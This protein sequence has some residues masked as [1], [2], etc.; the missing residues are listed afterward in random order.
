[1]ER[2]LQIADEVELF[3][4]RVM[5]LEEKVSLSPQILA[6]LTEPFSTIKKPGEFES[7]YPKLFWTNTILVVRCSFQP[8][9]IK[10]LGIPK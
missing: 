1:M 5:T 7:K 3:Q 10:Y 2:I 4:K 6:N 8:V 9:R